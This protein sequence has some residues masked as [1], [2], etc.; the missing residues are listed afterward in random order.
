[1]KKSINL[2]RLI[3]SAMLLALAIILPFITGQIREIGKMLCP[4]HIPVILC[5]FLCGGPWGLLV[6]VCA[7]LLRSM[8]FG[9]PLLFPS[10]VG[11]S[12]ELGAYGLLSGILYQKLPKKRI[13]IYIALIVSMVAGRLIW[14][15]ARFVLGGLNPAEF[16]FSLFWAGAVAEAIPGIILQIALIPPFVALFERSHILKKA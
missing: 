11:M 1:M 12:F 8:L 16:N 4:M 6:G 14:G 5:G 7:P 3:F 9:M 13:N 10:A 15:V 2:Q